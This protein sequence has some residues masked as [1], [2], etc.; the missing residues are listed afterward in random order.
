MTELDMAV[1][2]GAANYL[3]LLEAELAV[4]SPVAVA[5]SGGVDSMTLAVIAHR[6]DPHSLM[7]H[8]VSPAVPQSATARVK[9]YAEMEGWNLQLVDAGEMADP[10]YR[11]NPINRCYYCKTNLYHTL[12]SATQ[13]IGK[14]MTI[15]SGTNSDDLSDYRP[16]LQ[17][18]VEHRVVHP[19]VNVGIDKQ[20]VRYIAGYL[21]LADLQDLPAAPCL[22]SRVTTGIAIDNKLLPVIDEVES[23]V[24]R[25][26]GDALGL[27]TVR[28]RI[29][30]RSISIQLEGSIDFAE[31]N[32][33]LQALRQMAQRIFHR[34]GYEALQE[35]AIEPYRKG[36]AFLM[37]EK[38]AGDRRA[39][40]QRLPHNDNLIKSINV[41]H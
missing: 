28:C 37:D 6:V 14:Q 10:D 27:K 4:L 23:Q 8:A 21:G 19:Y 9:H 39:V 2:K 38:L 36:S 22:S 5:V 33:Q 35:V 12:R 20:T 17:A 16:G 31:S 3:S 40:G 29:L 15:V 13:V 24:W 11:A 25:H 41:E 18:A 34:N 30:T 32:T 26:Y 7:Y 1:F